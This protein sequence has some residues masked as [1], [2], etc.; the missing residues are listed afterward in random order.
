M[1]VTPAI[2]NFLGI[3]ED[4]VTIMNLLKEH[5]ELSHSKMAKEINKSQTAIGLRISKLEKKHLIKTVYGMNIFKSGL[6][7]AIIMLNVKKTTQFIQDARECPNVLNAFSALG[8]YNAIVWL[9]GASIEVIERVVELHFRANS[10]VLKL[11]MFMVFDSLKDFFFP[12]AP[13]FIKSNQIGLDTDDGIIVSRLM[14]E[15]GITFS[16]IGRE[17]G[18]SQPAVGAR[19]SKLKKKNVLS[20]VKGTNFKSS[21]QLKLVQLSITANSM[22]DVIEKLKGCHSILLGF[23]TL[24]EK[25]V[26]AYAASHSLN[27][28]DEF[29]DFTLRADGSIKDVETTVIIR[30]LNDLVIPSIF[31]TSCS[32]C[33]MGSFCLT[34]TE[35]VENHLE[36]PQHNNSYLEV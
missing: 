16:S 35:R 27:D 1:S 36:M 24:G 12:L 26:I 18:K 17:M 14:E 30:F 13:A 33:S 20:L 9:V 29:V 21:K 4:D 8:D 28:I 22:V 2:M 11:T 7:F 6:K 34:T 32:E 23:R 15:P 25:S 31:T 5:P 19:I 10:N 3:D